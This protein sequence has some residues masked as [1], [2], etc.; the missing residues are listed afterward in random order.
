MR[1]PASNPLGIGEPSGWRMLGATPSNLGER[2]TGWNQSFGLRSELRC[3][4]SAGASKQTS[5]PVALSDICDTQDIPGFSLLGVVILRAQ[6]AYG[7]HVTQGGGPAERL[8]ELCAGNLG[9][10]Q[11]SVAHPVQLACAH[12]EVIDLR[13]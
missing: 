6:F 2:P 9:L 5:P 10:P 4:D 3:W 1:P 7:G 8:F 12:M 13:S 11:H